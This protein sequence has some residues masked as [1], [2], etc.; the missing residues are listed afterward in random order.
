MAHFAGEWP[1]AEIVKAPFVP[2]PKTPNY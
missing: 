1:L 2:R